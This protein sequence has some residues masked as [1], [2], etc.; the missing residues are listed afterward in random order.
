MQKVYII[1]LSNVTVDTAI[2]MPVIGG[3]AYLSYEEAEKKALEIVNSEKAKA[4][5]GFLGGE[6]SFSVREFNVE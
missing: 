5:R 3:S 1:F 2:S 4:A 6:W